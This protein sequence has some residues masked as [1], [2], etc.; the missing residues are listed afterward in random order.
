[1][2]DLYPG[3]FRKLNAG[4]FQR[5]GKGDAGLLASEGHRN[6]RARPGVEHVLADYDDRTPAALFVPPDRIQVG[7]NHIALQ[8]SGHS[9]KSSASPS[10][11]SAC[12][13]FGSSLAHSRAS[14]LRSTRAIL[15]RTASWTAR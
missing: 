5:Q 15:S 9:L 3:A 14:R 10:S 1:M 12:S 6:D 4:E 2:T 7:P 11:A 8:Y 13:Y